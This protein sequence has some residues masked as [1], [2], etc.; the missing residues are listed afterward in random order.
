[1]TKSRRVRMGVSAILILAMLVPIAIVGFFALSLANIQRNEAASQVAADLSAKYGANA[2][3]RE[4]PI[5]MITERG[6]SIARD[7]WTH[8]G[9]GQDSNLDKGQVAVEIEYGSTRFVNDQAEFRLGDEPLNSVRVKTAVPAGIVIFG[10]PI[11]SILV[12]S[13]AAVANVERD[14]CLV[15]DRSGSM[16]FDLTTHTWS[17]DKSAHPKNRLALSTNLSK[18]SAANQWW[19]GWPHPE[20]SRWA[21]M[22]PAVYALADELEKTKQSELLSIVSYSSQVTENR[23]DQSTELRS[24]SSLESTIEAQPTLRYA[25]V[26]SALEHKYNE[27]MPIMGGTN[28]ASGIDQA[29]AVLTG[30]RSRS[31]AFKTMIVMTDGQHNVGRSPVDAARDAANRGIEVFTVTFSHDADVATMQATAAAGNGKH[32][33]AADGETLRQIFIEIANTPPGVFIE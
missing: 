1:M 20:N 16:T 22:M 3:A 17:A 11:G 32:F 10:K 19:W 26:V 12:D 7:N 30:S 21:E 6:T 5:D 25:D 27:V 33:H 28:I 18:R 23:W 14:L 24:Y 13:A 9:N 29:A 4:L 2:I 8:G 15:I 31:F